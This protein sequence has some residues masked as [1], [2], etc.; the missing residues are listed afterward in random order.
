[1][2]TKFVEINSDITHEKVRAK[3]HEFVRQ[4]AAEKVRSIKAA[5]RSNT[6]RLKMPGRETSSL[7]GLSEAEVNRLIYGVRINESDL[8]LREENH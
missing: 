1:M 4:V 3:I 5:H 7:L 6:S 2:I 8:C